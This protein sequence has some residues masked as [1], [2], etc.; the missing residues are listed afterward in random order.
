MS[1]LKPCPFC[2]G[3]VTLEKYT[4]PVSYTDS[5]G[6][7]FWRDEP[8]GWMIECK[9]HGW[10]DD[11]KG[12]DVAGDVALYSWGT[13][14]ENKR[15]LIEAW[16]T[17]AESEQDKCNRERLV[18]IGEA[19]VK[20]EPIHFLTGETYVPERTCKMVPF[21]EEDDAIFIVNCSE[22]GDAIFARGGEHNCNYCPNCGAEVIGSSKYEQGASSAKVVE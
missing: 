7:T 10:S 13:S 3:K 6:K 8:D 17:R 14:E 12:V 19:V 4:N 20:K 22:C 9:N 2:G 5:E 21:V 15:A 11:A 1:K 18:Q 16:N